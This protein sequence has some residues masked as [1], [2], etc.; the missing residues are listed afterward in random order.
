LPGGYY[1]GG[2]FSIAG[3]YGFWWTATEFVASIACRRDMY[4][5]YDSVLESTTDKSI[6]FS[7]R[8]LEN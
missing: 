2:S 5:N 8:C 1:N 4:Y 3:N 6:G 7:L